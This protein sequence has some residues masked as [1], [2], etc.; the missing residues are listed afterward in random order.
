M[1]LV[2][3][4]VVV[5]LVAVPI[6]FGLWR[7]DSDPG[8]VRIDGSDAKGTVL[9]ALDATVGSGS[10][11]LTFTFHVEPGTAAP[12]APVCHETKETGVRSCTEVVAV[13]RSVDV[14]GQGTVNTDPYAMTVV[15]QVSNLGLIT[16]FVNGTSVWEVGGAGYG[17]DGSGV[18]NSPGAR[19]SRASPVSWKAP[20]VRV[21]ARSR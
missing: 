17:V 3:A 21:R 19:H 14:T 5:A 16:L 12:S 8:T 20:S 15:S 9:A 6:V 7:D 10:Y 1:L 2:A 4:A 11:D 18:G 13:Q